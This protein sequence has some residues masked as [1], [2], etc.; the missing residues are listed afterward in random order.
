MSTKAIKKLLIIILLIVVLSLNCSKVF[1]TELVNTEDQYMEL[2]VVSTKNID[3]GDKQ[4][5][6]EWWSYN[7]NFKALDLRFS[8]DEAKLKPSSVQDNSYVTDETSFEFAGDFA[9]YMGYMVLSAEDG[10]YRCVMSLDEYDD[11]GTYIENDESLGYIVN[12]NVDGGVLMGRMSFRLFSGKID[13]T[14]FA[15]KTA[16]TS[17][18][19]GIKI[20]QTSSTAYED[21]SVFRF[22]VLSSDAKLSK[23]EYDFFNYNEEDDE[24]VLPEL[25]YKSLDLSKPDADS[26]DDVSKYTINL[27]EN[28]DNISLKLEKSDEDATVKIDDEEMDL[29]NSKELV[30]NNLGEEDTIIDIVVTARDGTIHTYRLVIHRPYGIIKGTIQYDLIEQ[31]ENPDIDKT[32]DLNI[33][34][35]GRFNWDE[36]KDIFGEVYDDPAT[37]D[38]LDALEK[39]EYFKSNADGSYEI[40]VVPGS[41]DLQIDK[42]GFLDY[43]VINI[44]VTEGSVIDLGNR[45]LTAGD[46]NRD[47]SNWTGGYSGSGRAYGCCF[48]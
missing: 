11:T 9:S 19:S 32:T 43:I 34:K 23:I 47:R 42:K 2:R 6:L 45:I 37:Y 46:V 18:K 15:L 36:L 8:Y 5:I 17:P 28:V 35:T 41:Y 27:L 39:D 31:N 33:Y 38:D 29:A 25:T 40:Y 4:V 22:S 1:A 14:T 13:E 30:L 26:T 16:E 24:K 7:L 21:Q 3:G 44:D 20:A 48:G 10:E 12:T